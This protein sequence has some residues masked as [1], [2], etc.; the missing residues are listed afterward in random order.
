[1][2]R[3]VREKVLAEEKQEVAGPED[4]YDSA[5]KKEA[6]D[7]LDQQARQ[8]LEQK[9]TSKRKRKRSTTTDLALA[10]KRQQHELEFSTHIEK[11]MCSVAKALALPWDL[12]SAEPSR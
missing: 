7:P 1:V 4:T 6:G 11:V 9:Q 3:Q 10:S 5:D 8:R 12:D 2:Y